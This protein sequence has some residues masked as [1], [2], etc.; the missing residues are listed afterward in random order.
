MLQKVKSH[1]AQLHFILQELSQS[2]ENP[3][4]LKQ[5]VYP[6]YFSSQLRLVDWSSLLSSF[7]R[8]AVFTVQHSF[9]PGGK[10]IPLSLAS[11]SY[12]FFKELSTPALNSFSYA[13]NVTVSHSLHLKFYSLLLFIEKKMFL[14]FFF[15]YFY[16]SSIIFLT[17]L[18]L[19]FMCLFIILTDIWSIC[20]PF[21][22]VALWSTSFGQYYST[23]FVL[24]L[25]SILLRIIKALSKYHYAQWS[26]LKRCAVQYSGLICLNVTVAIFSDINVEIPPHYQNFELLYSMQKQ[27]LKKKK[28]SCSHLLLYFPPSGRLHLK[29][30]WGAFNGLKGHLFCISLMQVGRKSMLHARR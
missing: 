1:I 20:Y 2:S 15:R 8:F 11:P 3:N 13:N 25:K 23:C 27:D 28:C 12:F 7:K 10:W 30:P 4:L 16:F 5:F 21:S 26:W 6:R 18:C 24:I 17:T 14:H 22:L 29:S 19:V 9:A